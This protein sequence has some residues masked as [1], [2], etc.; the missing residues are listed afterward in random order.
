VYEALGDR[1]HVPGR[2]V[3]EARAGV[4]E[5]LGT[6]ALDP[7]GAAGPIPHGTGDVP[8]HEPA[9]LPVEDEA[10]E[11]W[12]GRSAERR[13]PE[14]MLGEGR[15]H[16]FG[17]SMVRSDSTVFGNPHPKRPRTFAD[18]FPRCLGSP[19]ATDAT[20]ATAVARG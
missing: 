5:P 15:D 8:T 11:S 18:A 2:G 13:K 10:L 20:H 1:L 17:R 16:N 19:D 7:R 9:M 3:G 14:Q 12:V 4:P 6:N